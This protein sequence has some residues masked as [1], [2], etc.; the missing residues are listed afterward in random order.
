MSG[1]FHVLGVSDSVF[2]QKGY[3]I[4]ISYKVTF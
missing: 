2:V 1:K 4:K 3:Y